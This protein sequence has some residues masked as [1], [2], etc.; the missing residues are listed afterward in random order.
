MM[1]NIAAETIHEKFEEVHANSDTRHDWSRDEISTLFDKPF[2][3]L[4]FE[5]ATIHRKFHDP[6][7]VQLSQLLSIKTGGCPEDCGYC[8]QAA[9]YSTGVSATKLMELEKV[10][11]AATKA[12]EAGASRY[13]LGAAWR[14]P[15]DREI[16]QVC[17]MVR[18]I[19]QL[20]LESCVTLGMLTPQQV[21]KL[22]DAGLDYYNHNIDTS[23]EHYGD[24]ISTR[25]I[26][27]RL[28]TIENVRSAGINVCSGGIVG[29]G[30][31][32]DDRVGMLQTLANL[33]HHP[34]SVPINQLVPVAGTPLASTPGVDPL[35]FVRVIA[36]ARILMPRSTIRLSAGRVQMSDEMHALCFL[37]GAN[38]IFFGD[39]LLTTENPQH[40]RDNRLFARLG[41]R[42][43]DL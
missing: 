19:K 14:S 43:L 23:P 2:A 9:R 21:C 31:S 29:L 22:K 39:T 26:V 10:L 20:G 7:K 32:Q 30:E 5:A 4:V 27:D 28:N 11:Q 37:S 42:P 33:P 17:N 24:V 6:N 12:K 13:C 40:A 3:D 34:E 1:F 16:D 8:P 41:I 25:S 38:S 15:K 18:G 36:V 35:E